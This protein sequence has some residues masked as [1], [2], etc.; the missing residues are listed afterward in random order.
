VSDLE[1]SDRFVVPEAELRER[2]SRSSGPGGQGVNT[3][4]SRVELSW[5]IASSP[6]IPEWL[7]ERLLARLA[8]RLASGV[9]TVAAS[10]QRAQLANR[11]EARARMASLLRSAAAPPPPQRRPTKPS[12]GAKERRLA[13]KRRR[14]QTKQGRRIRPDD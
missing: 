8:S 4:D 10:T 7:R 12:R 1:V 14:G 11:A 6:S 5:D 13:E 9:L 2:F 3:T